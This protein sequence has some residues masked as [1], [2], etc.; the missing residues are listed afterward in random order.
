MGEGEGKVRFMD[1][2]PMLFTLPTPGKLR[3]PASQSEVGR[4]NQK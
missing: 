1:Q 3:L 4:Q 2:Y